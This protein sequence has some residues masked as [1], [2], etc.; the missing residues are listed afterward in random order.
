MATALGTGSSDIG[1]DVTMPGY[2]EA[3][4]SNKCEIPQYMWKRLKSLGSKI[5]VSMDNLLSGNGEDSARVLQ[6]CPKTIP[7]FLD[8]LRIA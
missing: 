5:Y 2:S 3:V 4:A 7:G 8:K 1:R 6:P